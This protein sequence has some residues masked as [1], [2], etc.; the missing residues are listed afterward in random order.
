MSKAE[1]LC[2]T[3]VESPGPFSVC[4]NV[5]DPHWDVIQAYEDCVFDL[6]AQNLDVNARCQLLQVYGKKC[7]TYLDKSKAVEWENIGGCGKRQICY[8]S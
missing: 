1:K 3:M 6:C 8:L 7:Q 2:Y 4:V 5:T